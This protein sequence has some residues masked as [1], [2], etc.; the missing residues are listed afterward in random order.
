MEF[1]PIS[2]ALATAVIED[3]SIASIDLTYSGNGYHS[4]PIVQ[5]TDSGSGKDAR[6]FT[7]IENGKVTT[8]GK[9]EVAQGITQRPRKCKSLAA[10]IPPSIRSGWRMANQFRST[11]TPVTQIPW[12]TPLGSPFLSMGKI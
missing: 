7:S 10:M 9:I 1:Q 8:I 11:C 3:G 5:I 2:P 12:S 4:A 6:F